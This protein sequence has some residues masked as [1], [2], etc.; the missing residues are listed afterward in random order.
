MKKMAAGLER[1]LALGCAL[2]ALLSLGSL[3][4]GGSLAALGLAAVLLGAARALSLLAERSEQAA[5]RARRRRQRM[6]KRRAGRHVAASA[7]KKPGHAASR[8]LRVA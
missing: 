1:F 3:F 8:D 4:E 5:L 7:L 2:A 6:A